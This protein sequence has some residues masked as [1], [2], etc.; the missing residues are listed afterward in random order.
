[1]LLALIVTGC[2]SD[3]SNSTTTLNVTE[4]SPDEGESLSELPDNIQLSFNRAPDVLSAEQFEVL[5]SGGDGRFTDGNEVVLTISGVNQVGTLVTLDISNNT[6]AA[7]TYQVTA[8]GSGINGIEDDDGVLLDGDDDG[9]EGGD[10]VS[11]FIIEP[12]R[13]ALLSVIQTDIFNVNCA[14][15]GCHTGSS[16]RAGLNLSSGL[17]FSNIVSVLSSQNNSFTRVIPNDADN[18]LLVQK[19]EGTQTVGGRMPAG[20]RAPLSNEDI[21][22][23]RD[24]ITN[25]AE[26]N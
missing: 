5:A 14:L 23:I 10:F 22:L 17:A 1:M 20:G 15:S 3:S 24:W 11:Q 26:N 21:Q 9:T 2:G 19:I 25:G 8:L 4:I 18:S 12:P 6:D 16:P 7:D 13:A